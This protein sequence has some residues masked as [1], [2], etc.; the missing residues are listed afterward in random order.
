M[1]CGF[2]VHAEIQVHL[3]PQ[4]MNGFPRDDFHEIPR[5]STAH[6][7]DLLCRILPKYVNVEHIDRNSMK[8]ISKP[9]HDFHCAT[10]HEAYHN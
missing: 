2:T 5:Y 3:L 7:V 9:N 1:H 8:P 6:F 4:V 10:L